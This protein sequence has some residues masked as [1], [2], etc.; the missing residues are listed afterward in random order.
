MLSGTLLQTFVS[1]KIEWNVTNIIVQQGQLLFTSLNFGITI[2][3]QNYRNNHNHLQRYSHFS[4]M[5]ND[6]FTG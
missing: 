1:P 3:E 5:T 6:T 2:F 4:Y